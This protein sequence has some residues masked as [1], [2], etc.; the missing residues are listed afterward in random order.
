V[1]ARHARGGAAQRRGLAAERAAVAALQ[2][3]G[4]NVL[5]QRLR[6]PAGEIDLVARRGDLI[7]FIEVKCRPTLN[8]AA[9]ALGARQSRRLLLAA[10][11]LLAAR[12]DWQSSA[13]RFDVLLVDAAGRVRRITDALRAEL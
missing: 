8:Q 6:T 12:P 3:D 1:T 5:G 11:C 13:L 4:W 7:A 2:A 10:E 9:F